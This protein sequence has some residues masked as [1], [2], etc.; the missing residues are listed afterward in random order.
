MPHHTAVSG[1][2]DPL[3]HKSELLVVVDQRIL[4]G[5]NAA[6]PPLLPGVGDDP[7][8][9][10]PGAA[11]AAVSRQGV[12]AEDHLPGAVFIVEGGVFVHLVPKRGLVGDHAVHE[13]HQGAVILLQQPEVVGVHRQTGGYLRRRGGLRRREAGGLHRRQGVRVG[14]DSG[15]NVHTGLPFISD[16]DSTAAAARW[17]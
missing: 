7:P 5:E 8:E 11:P 2:G 15:P 14:G 16:S 3:V 1:L 17:R 4:A 6:P 10:L 13:A 12:D 9:H